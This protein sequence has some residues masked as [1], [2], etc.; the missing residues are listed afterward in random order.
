MLAQALGDD[1]APTRDSAGELTIVPNSMIFKNPVEILTDEQL[2]RPWGDML[3]LLQG[4]DV[5]L[6]TL[7]TVATTSD[8]H[9]P[10][11]KF[12]EERGVL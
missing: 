5:T 2:R 4:A 9:L 1:L 3:P 12:L 8:I 6:L 10:A 11:K 7:E